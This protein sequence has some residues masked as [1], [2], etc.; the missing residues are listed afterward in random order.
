[1]WWH[2][3]SCR[4]YDVFSP[5]DIVT[6]QQ[7]KQ[8]EA[9]EPVEDEKMQSSLRSDACFIWMFMERQA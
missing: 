2:L 3:L 8:P 6:T 9:C 4:L 5:A 1:M 7:E